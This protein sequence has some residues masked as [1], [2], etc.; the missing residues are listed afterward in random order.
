MEID[1]LLIGRGLPTHAFAVIAR[2]VYCW[3]LQAEQFKK[4][5]QSIWIALAC[6]V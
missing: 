4:P 1:Y 2:L 3:S 6:L 5:K